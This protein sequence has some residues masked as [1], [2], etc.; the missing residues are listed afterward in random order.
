MPT[1][2][3]IHVRQYFLVER[4]Y[5]VFC[6]KVG[7]FLRRWPTSNPKI[8]GKTWLFFRF[9]CV[10]RFLL[11][12]SI[13]KSKVPVWTMTSPPTRAKQNICCIFFSHKI[14]KFGTMA[15]YFMKTIYIKNVAMVS[16]VNMR[17]QPSL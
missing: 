14:V 12:C 4:R 8:F 17:G 13:I 3:I 6:E 2:Y 1:Y 7:I 10:V 16:S 9:F 15:K 5:R 11:T